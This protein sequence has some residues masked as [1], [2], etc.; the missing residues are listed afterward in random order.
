[1]YHNRCSYLRNVKMGQRLV[2]YRLRSRTS[3]SQKQTSILPYTLQREH[4]PSSLCLDFQPPHQWECKG[5]ESRSGMSSS[6]RPHGIYNPW[7]SPG[8]NAGV[9]S[10]SLLQGIFPTQGLKP[11]FPHCRRI[12]YQLSHKRSPRILELVA[13]PFSN[14]SSQPRELD[15]CLLYCRWIPY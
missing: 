15:W 6:L 12:L 10:L 4:A 8:Q 5:K 9:G 3:S 13:Y 2:L 11:G 1:M 7:N 14:R